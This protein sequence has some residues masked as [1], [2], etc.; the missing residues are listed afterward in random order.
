MTKAVLNLILLWFYL[1]INLHYIYYNHELKGRKQWLFVLEFS[2]FLSRNNY[3]SS[4]NSYFP[5]GRRQS[6]FFNHKILKEKKKMN[7]ITTF[8]WRIAFLVICYTHDRT[9]YSR[10][11]R[12]VSKE[13]FKKSS[14]RELFTLNKFIA[15]SCYQLFSSE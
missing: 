12:N 15:W 10:C 4:L 1:Y 14:R 6:V 2:L 13:I 5:R 8:P 9:F 3:L 11:S 7:L